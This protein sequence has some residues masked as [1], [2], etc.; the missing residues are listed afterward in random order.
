[1]GKRPKSSALAPETLEEEFMAVQG[2][3]FGDLVVVANSDAKASTPEPG[4]TRKVLAYND[5]L[6]LA[7]HRMEKGWVGS[8]HSHPHEQIVYVVRGHLKVTCQGKTF[9]VRTGDTF[10][11]RGGVEHGASA[12]E[13]SLVIDVFTPCREDY[14]S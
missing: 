5:K 9:E 4:L 7:E 14:I 10:A 11:V 12:L 6:F 13:E 8:V 3:V 2:Q 1:M